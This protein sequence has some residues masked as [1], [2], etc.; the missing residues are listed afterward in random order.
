MTNEE[1]ALKLFRDFDRLKD[2]PFLCSAFLRVNDRGVPY[3]DVEFQKTES[4]KTEKMSYRHE[5]GGIWSRVVNTETIHAK[6]LRTP[7]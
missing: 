7:R 6:L 1:L 2:E 5:S 4:S 3:L